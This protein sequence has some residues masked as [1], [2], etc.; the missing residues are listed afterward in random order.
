MARPF[1]PSMGVARPP[2]RQVPGWLHALAMFVTLVAAAW[3]GGHG[4][5]PAPAT[6]IWRAMFIMAIVWAAGCIAAA[7]LFVLVA[8]VIVLLDMAD[9]AS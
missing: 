3:L 7:G 1:D 6:L 8:V 5:I 4:G 2:R 9:N